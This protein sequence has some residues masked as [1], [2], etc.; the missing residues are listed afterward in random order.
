MNEQIA[1]ELNDAFAQSPLAQSFRDEGRR[2]AI[3]GAKV[4]VEKL[5][6]ATLMNRNAFPD[7]LVRKSD[8][9]TLLTTLEK[10]PTPPQKKQI[11]N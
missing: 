6:S 3:E 9:L 8:I 5:L 11:T 1:K 10:P 2:Q 7:D 4:E